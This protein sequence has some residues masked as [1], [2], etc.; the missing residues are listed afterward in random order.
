MNNSYLLYSS[1]FSGQGFYS[2]EAFAIN[3]VSRTNCVKTSSFFKALFYQG[4]VVAYFYTYSALLSFCR[5]LFFKKTV[6][7][8][9]CD[10]LSSYYL[11]KQNKLV[12]LMHFLLVCVSIIFSTKILAVSQSD[13]NSLSFIASKLFLKDRIKF[14]LH[15]VSKAYSYATHIRVD[16]P[17]F[18]GIT[19]CWQG[20]EEN[21]LRKGLDRCVKLYNILHANGLDSTFTIVGKTGPGTDYLS[22]L[23]HSC[24]KPYLFHLTDYLETSIVQSL[25]SE[26][27]F[28]LQLSRN[29]GFGLSLCEA[30]L[31]GS[32]II[33]SDVGGTQ[34][35]VISSFAS[36]IDCGILEALDSNTYLPYSKILKLFTDAKFSDSISRINHSSLFN[37]IRRSKELASAFDL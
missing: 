36:L 29:E 19:I 1:S 3:L 31:L 12:F 16:C 13:F 26:I 27:P 20:T 11:G 15:S 7:T 22:R 6:L 25:L 35:A 9:G 8:G 21:V 2:D 17:S 32:K 28:Y 33:Y 24:S 10:Q 4:N 14:S 34:N 5:F 23:I 30:S 18:N 37:P